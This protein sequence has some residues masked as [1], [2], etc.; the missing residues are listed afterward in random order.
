MYFVPFI[1]FENLGEVGFLVSCRYSQYQHS[2][3][4]LE[5]MEE[6]KHILGAVCYV[7]IQLVE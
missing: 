5:D 1:Q 3:L 2:L 6:V 4:K 7:H